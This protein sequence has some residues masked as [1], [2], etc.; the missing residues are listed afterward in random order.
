MKLITNRLPNGRDADKDGTVMA[1]DEI[2]P[3]PIPVRSVDLGVNRFVGWRKTRQTDY[4]RTR[5][6]HTGT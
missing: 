5:A 4:R 3:I 2:G 1:Y 6:I